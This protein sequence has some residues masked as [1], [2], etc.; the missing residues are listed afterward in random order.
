MG[1][2]PL[3]LLGEAPAGQPVGQDYVPHVVAWNLTRRCNLECAHCYIAAGPQ[4]QATDELSTDECLR[5]AGE[6]LEVN[7]APLFILSGG[8][9]LLREDLAEIARFATDRGATVVVGTN[10]TLLTD[11]RI[12]ELKAAGVTGLAVS[13][14]S[15]HAG[16]HDRFRRGHGALEA[17]LAG[18]ERLRQHQLDFIVQTTLTKGNQDQL[19]E[20]V[21]WSAAQGAVSFNAYFLVATGR[22]DRLSDLSPGDYEVLLTQLVDL[23][24]RYLGR[25]MVRAKCAPHFMRLVHQ[26]VP[27]SPV[28]NYATRCPCGVQYCR[29]TP[30][31][32]LTA[33]PYMPL[34]AG[35]LRHTAFASVWREAPLFRALRTGTLGGKCG[36]CEYRRLCGGCRARAYALEKDPM[37]ADPSCVYEPAGDIPVIEIARAVTYGM[38]AQPALR[39]AAEAEARVQR[40][41][42]FVRAVV[43]QR[44]ED[45]ARRHGRTE[46]TLDLLSEVRSAMPVDF[47][48]RKPFFLRD[49]D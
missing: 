33:C 3:A 32:K 12:E 21:E 20:L 47:S 17:T 41:P 4:E 26:R 34:P 46:V 2:T 7:P 19:E 38:T 5:I 6:I 18:V 10:G 36:I 24:V 48:K 42:S 9:P 13:I 40:I 28:L 27:D 16:Y 11:T 44:V 45:Y 14:E 25:M 29:V 15:L 43:M 23:H 49:D 39:W 37:A 8:E 30:D 22:G 31:G 1:A 35:D